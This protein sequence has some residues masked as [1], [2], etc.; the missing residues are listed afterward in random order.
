MNRV[1]PLIVMAGACGA[2]GALDQAQLAG[3][4]E[5]QSGCVDE[6]SAG[7]LAVGGTVTTSIRIDAAGS[8]TATLELEAANTDVLEITGHQLTGVSPGMSA[9]IVT[10]TVSGS[11]VDFFHLY[12]AE[13]D[14]LELA[15]LG[16]VGAGQ[17][18]AGDIELLSGDELTLG[19]I[20]Y[21]GP[22]RLVG[23]GEVDWLVSGDA[24]TL[25]SDGNPDRRRVVAR[26]PGTA[27]IAIDSMGM[28][29]TLDITVLP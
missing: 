7:P 16:G 1:L 29:Q 3:E 27:T 4:C 23:T 21:R 12:V 13:P 20:A 6:L 14:R 10:E 9:V 24:V 5:G 2:G 19:V 8:G 11:V 22:Q 28:S 15:R 26:T 25:L 18:L 17:D